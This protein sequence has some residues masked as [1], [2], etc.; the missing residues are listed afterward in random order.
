MHAWQPKELVLTD[1][2]HASSAQFLA[3]TLDRQ[4]VFREGD[5]LP[6]AWHWCYFLSAAKRSNLGYDGHAE[7]GDFLPPIELPR[8]MWG[9]SRFVFHAPL[10][11]GETITRRSNV[12]A[13]KETTGKSGKLAF[14]TVKHDYLCAAGTT[15]LEEEH[16]IVYR[17]YDAD[18]N[19]D[20]PIV[21]EMAPRV[22]DVNETI[23]PDPVLLFRYS[24]LT[25]NGHRI[26][27][28][29]RFCREE[30]GYRHLVVHGPLVATLLINLAADHSGGRSIRRFDFKAKSPL[31]SDAPFSI[32]GAREGDAMALWAA[33]AQGGLA[34]QARATY[35]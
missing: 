19:P 31:F 21:A 12:I 29:L 25:F 17:G 15:R 18:K 32:H 1:T 35:S 22:A 4:A 2:L 13:V 11:I 14:V 20:R 24:A 34:M 8:R 23:T 28:D 7:K 9:G 5:P 30:E 33:N 6:H 3:A 27:Y 16:D 10:R 26:H